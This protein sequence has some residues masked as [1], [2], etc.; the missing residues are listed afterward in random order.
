M[1]LADDILFLLREFP[2]GLD[3]D[4]IADRLHLSRRQT[5]NQVARHLAES[6]RL[7]RVPVS[8]KI[9][10]FLPGTGPSPQQQSPISPTGH[11][12]DRVWHWEGNVQA[13]IV[14]RLQAEGW[15]VN[16]VDTASKQRGKDII[17]TKEHAQ[18]WVT[19]K[20]YPEGTGTT[21]P[22]T[23]ARHWFSHAIFD[24]VQYR[25]ENDEVSL[26]VGL[27]DFP[28]YRALARKVEWLEQSAPFSYLWVSAPH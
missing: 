16:F 7:K 22:S 26:A 21:N 17:A 6:G 23:Q 5:A 24:V 8:G 19:V 14:E 13:S 9:R 4:E 11:N 25:N 3:D 2:D 15:Q 20:G 18:L 10:N 28:T 12:R 1:A 27:P